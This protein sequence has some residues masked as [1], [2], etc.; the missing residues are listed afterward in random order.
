[1]YTDDQINIKSLLLQLQSRHCLLSVG[2]IVLGPKPL[3]TLVVVLWHLAIDAPGGVRV[4]V[5]VFGIIPDKVVGE[6]VSEHNAGPLLGQGEVIDVAIP[7]NDKAGPVPVPI[8]A[9]L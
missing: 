8:A 9:V 7:I 3:H 6:A 1:M 4:V 5:A 2:N